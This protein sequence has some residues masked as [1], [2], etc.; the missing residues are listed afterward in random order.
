MLNI[1][2]VFLEKVFIYHLSFKW[3]EA[4]EGKHHIDQYQSKSH[5]S[6]RQLNVASY[7]ISHQEW[8]LIITCFA[9]DYEQ[10]IWWTK[11]DT[12]YDQQLSL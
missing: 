10:H 7:S 1:D 2:K 5:P 11:I 12:I 4:S 6:T 9:Y 3:R 8:F